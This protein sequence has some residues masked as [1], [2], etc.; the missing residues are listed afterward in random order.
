[1]VSLP[2]HAHLCHLPDAAPLIHHGLGIHHAGCADPFRLVAEGLQVFLDVGKV[3][4]GSRDLPVQSRELAQHFLDLGQGRLLGLVERGFQPAQLLEAVMAEEHVH[5]GSKLLFPLVQL[6]DL[7][8]EDCYLAVALALPLLDGVQDLLPRVLCPLLHLVDGGRPHLPPGNHLQP[9]IHVVH[10]LTRG[11]SMNDAG[12]HLAVLGGKE[13]RGKD[14]PA[15]QQPLGSDELPV[16]PVGNS[17]PEVPVRGDELGPEL[18][19]LL[20]VL[21]LHVFAEQV[22]DPGPGVPFPG[23]HFLVEVLVLE[24]GLRF[25]LQLDDDG[26]ALLGGVDLLRGRLL[27]LLSGLLFAEKGMKVRSPFRARLRRRASGSLCRE[28]PPDQDRAHSAMST[29][30]PCHPLGLVEATGI[31]PTTS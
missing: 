4:V 16:G 17:R 24:V 20:R 14:A 21:G 12:H 15:K 31:E 26:E 2:P 22:M 3:P 23:K 8:A 29:L 6:A 1:M 27:R 30:L 11:V 13:A 7:G 5:L 18:R 25:L 10:R 9:L 19:L 28:A